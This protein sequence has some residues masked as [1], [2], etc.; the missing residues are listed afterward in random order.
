[1]TKAVRAASADPDV[2]ALSDEADTLK[3]ESALLVSRLA[4]QMEVVKGRMA[5]TKFADDCKAMLG[6]IAS[7]P[8]LLAKKESRMVEIKGLVSRIA[9][10]RTVGY[11]N[12]NA[13]AAQATALKERSR[14][15][16]ADESS[17]GM[18]VQK[19]AGNYERTFGTSAIYRLKR[20][21]PE[22]AA[23]ARIAA[24]LAALKSGFNLQPGADPSG[25]FVN[26]E[27]KSYQLAD[28]MEEEK[29]LKR[30][31]ETLQAVRKLAQRRR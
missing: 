17:V 13:L 1:M 7:V 20:E 9:G 14:K 4:K 3:R 24:E 18:R 5:V 29:L 30:L 22:P 11:A 2:E 27:S 16:G 31:D 23:Q 25:A 15:E 6:G 19:L 10:S 8:A 26:L 12:L 21:V 28:R